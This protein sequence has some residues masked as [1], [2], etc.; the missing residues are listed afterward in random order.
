MRQVFGSFWLVSLSF[1]NTPD[2]CCC[3]FGLNSNRLIKI[4]Q[5]GIHSLESTI[6]FEGYG[7]HWIIIWVFGTVHNWMLATETFRFI[8]SMKKVD[9]TPKWKLCSDYNSFLAQLNQ[10][11]T[12]FVTFHSII[13]IQSIRDN[14]I[15]NNRCLLSL[16]GNHNYDSNP[17]SYIIWFF[18]L[19][20]HRLFV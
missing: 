10:T 1:S 7:D 4:E 8:D 12:I 5:S 18:Q 6:V 17:I 13:F 11:K 14:D 2:S 16:F 20:S 3:F 9:M 19:K 15:A